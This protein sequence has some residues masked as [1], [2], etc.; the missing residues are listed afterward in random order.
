MIVVPGWE[1][2]TV[3]VFPPETLVV[4]D[5]K[6]NMDGNVCQTYNEPQ[7]DFKAHDISHEKLKWCEVSLRD[8]TQIPETNVCG[9][10]E[11][12]VERLGSTNEVC[13]AVLLE[14]VSGSDEALTHVGDLS[15]FLELYLD[16]DI[17]FDVLTCIGDCSIF[18]KPSMCGPVEVFDA[19]QTI[20]MD[21]VLNHGVGVPSKGCKLQQLLSQEMHQQGTNCDTHVPWDPGQQKAGIN[22][23]FGCRR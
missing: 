10:E 2:V 12:E 3:D 15:L 6:P 23:L 1:H 5:D 22:N 21:K 19:P 16:R 11:A 8:A 14:D 20:D 13:D 18:V 7:D 9:Y 17:E 4:S